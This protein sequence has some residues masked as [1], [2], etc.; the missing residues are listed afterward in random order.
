M[1]EYTGKENLD[2]L[3]T[4]PNYLNEIEG[5]LAKFLGN[6]SPVLDFG[7][8][9]GIYARR[10]AAKNIKPDCVEIDVEYQQKLSAAGFNTSRSLAETPQ[11]YKRIY[12]CD[13]M[14]HIEDDLAAFK[15]LR[16]KLADGGKIFIYVPAFY[17]LYSDMDKKIGH[18]RRYRKAELVNKMKEAG[19]K[20]DSAQYIDFIGFFGGLYYKHFISKDG[21]IDSKAT[22]FYYKYIFPVSRVLDKLG[23]RYLLGKNLLVIAS[24]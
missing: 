19:F 22:R 8:G 13:V 15:E 16:A 20:I 7:A 21:S 10:L 6:E 9:S 24:K 12:S 2:F 14:E 5:I 3:E 23:G 4:V 11:I 1:T 17:M 18:F